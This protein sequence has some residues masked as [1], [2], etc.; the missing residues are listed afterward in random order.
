MTFYYLLETKAPQREVVI[1]FLDFPAL[2]RRKRTKI[3]FILKLTKERFT[4][5][6]KANNHYHFKSGAP[7]LFALNSALRPLFAW[8]TLSGLSQGCL[9]KEGLYLH[10]CPWWIHYEQAAKKQ[11]IY[12]NSVSHENDKVYFIWVHEKCARSIS[13]PWTFY[14]AFAILMA[15]TTDSGTI[16]NEIMI[17]PS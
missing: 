3:S 17:H 7:G 15:P 4:S 2:D 13:K 14:L 8:V 1:P 11:V 5:C 9:L 12:V 6:T 10:H 16:L